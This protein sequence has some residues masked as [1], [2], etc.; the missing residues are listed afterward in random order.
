MAIPSTPFV[1]A[2][3]AACLGAFALAPAQAGTFDVGT[4]RAAFMQQALGGAFVVED[5]GLEP[6][7]PIHTGVLNQHT[8]IEPENEITLLP[9]RIVPGVTFSTPV[10]HGYFF[11]IDEGDAYE[12]AFLDGFY[13]GHASRR[14]TVDFDAPV[15]AFGF[16][17]NRLAPNLEVT[18]TFTDLSTATFST[19]VSSHGMSFFG[20]TSR[21]G[22][23]ILRV[24]IGGDDNPA[25]A[26]ALDNFTFT[27]AVPEPGTWGL[28]ALGLAALGARARRR[29]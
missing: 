7:F 4:D 23:D 19:V 27:T 26:F 17:T 29:G 25:F 24:T 8:H 18:V 1:R 16:D 11:N 5:F 12:G 13:G 10:G 20:F 6:H 28:M 22:W 3:A 9:G 14:L 15:A 2:A 21:Q